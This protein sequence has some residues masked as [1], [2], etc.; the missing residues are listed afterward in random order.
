MAKDVR[1]ALG[2]AD[3]R[4]FYTR[5]I[6][7]RE[8]NGKRRPGGGL[9]WSTSSFDAVAWDAL[10]AT[11]D[12]KGQMYK[13]WL[14][15]QSSGF[16]GTQAMVSHWDSTRDDKCP[17]CGRRETASH[18]NL[19]SDPD[20][21]Q[22]LHEM[23][24][25]LQRWLN[26]SFT[27]PELAYWLPKYILLRGTRRL[28][29]FPYLSPAM[30]KVAHSQDSI[31]W[32]SFMEGKLSKEIFHLQQHTLSSL[33]SR[34]TIADWS[35]R[36]I[37]QILQILHA[38]WIFRNVSLHDAVQGYLRVKKRETVLQEVDRLSSVDPILLPEASR[39]LLEIDFSSLHRG[40]LEKQ[41]YWLLAMKAA[42]R[43]GRRTV[44][45]SCNATAQ[46]RRAAAYASSPRMVNG[47]GNPRTIMAV[48]MRAPLS[49]TTRELRR[50][51]AYTVAG[52]AILWRVQPRL[53]VKFIWIL[54]PVLPRP[55]GVLLPHLGS[56]NIEIPNGGA[57]I[58]PLLP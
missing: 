19:C 12:G 22:L 20:R 33:P 47:G 35:K 48:S 3:A 14:C 7:P 54:A 6:H 56:W 15:K 29:S 23:V 44:A 38:Q 55:G 36:L 26:D 40:T 5:P 31:P 58:E 16:C 25:Q 46:Q 50:R 11:L 53:S 1:F 57:R 8:A 28:S 24:D 2:R 30:Q 10:D 43:A 49:R 27:H 32:T 52:A 34:L 37:S 41:S 51:Q 21:T 4:E 39:Y 18:L 17:D 13:Q 42:V 45:R 9:G